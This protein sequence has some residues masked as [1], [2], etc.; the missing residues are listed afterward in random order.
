MNEKT[1]EYWSGE[2]FDA[3]AQ[4]LY[5]AGDYDG[6]LDLLKRALALYPDAVELHVSL[7]YTRLAREEYPWARGGFERALA[8]EPDH[9][10]ALAGLGEALLKLGERAR[11]FLAFERLLDLGFESD[12]ELMLCVGRALLRE[13][14]LDRA[15]RFFRLAV[16]ADDASSEAALDLAYAMYQKNDA[17]AALRWAREAVGRDPTFH[18]ARCLFGS[19][20][21]E[22]GDFQAALAQLERVPPAAVS[23]PVVAWRTV[24]L[25]RRLRGLSADSAAVRPYMLVLDELSVEPGPEDRLLAEVEARASGLFAGSDGGRSQLDL[26]GRP[27]IAG[28]DGWHRV[29]AADGAVYEGDWEAIVRAMRDRQ[30]DSSLS[31][32]EF[33]RDEARRLQALTGVPV[34]CDDARRFIEESARLGA[35]EIER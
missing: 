29:R 17:E 14:L 4:R 32:Q 3:E 19:L 10:E 31:V 18:E 30:G 11:A 15:E 28:P 12:C 7:G 5:E 2:Q 21:Y 33:M 22:R 27:P 9:E 1:P 23:D 35:L 25:L 13:S 20:L 16:E 6:A 8:F 34:P 26:F 24:E